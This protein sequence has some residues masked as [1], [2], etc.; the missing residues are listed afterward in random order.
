MNI[1][2]LSAMH[3]LPLGYQLCIDKYFQLIELIV[4]NISCNL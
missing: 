3:K 4:L 1:S 2:F